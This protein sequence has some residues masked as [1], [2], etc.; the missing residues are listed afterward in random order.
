MMAKASGQLLK[1]LA[2]VELRDP[3]TIKQENRQLLAARCCMP[4]ACQAGQE[5]D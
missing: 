3:N 1:Q 2:Q 5:K 4:C